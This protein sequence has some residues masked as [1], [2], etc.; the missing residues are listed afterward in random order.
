MFH[1]V[2]LATGRV[3]KSYNTAGWARREQTR[4]IEHADKYFGYSYD[5]LAVMSAD[6]YNRYRD[7]YDPM[8]EV[9][10]MMSGK[11]V[12][13]RK[14]EAGSCCDPSTETYWSS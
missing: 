3:L 4:L 8:V 9:I 10:N 1:V 13:I 11:P 2:H 5:T 14:S 6:H 7:K 12:K